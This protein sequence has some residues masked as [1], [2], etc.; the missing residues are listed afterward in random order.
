[1]IFIENSLPGNIFGSGFR[2]ATMRDKK[3]RL[4]D[5]DNLWQI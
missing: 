2:I 3:K 1:M 4:P 5:T